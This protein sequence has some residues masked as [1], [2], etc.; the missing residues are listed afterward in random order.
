VAGFY[1]QRKVVAATPE[2]KVNF[3][4]PGLGGRPVRNFLEELFLSGG[5]GQARVPRRVNHAVILPGI[6]TTTLKGASPPSCQCDGA[7]G[8]LCFSSESTANSM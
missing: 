8:G 4:W 2:Q 3:C 7:A 5:G 1:F 6:L